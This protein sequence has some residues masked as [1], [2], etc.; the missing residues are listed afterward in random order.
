MKSI[1]PITTTSEL[2][3]LAAVFALAFESEYQLSE[4]YASDMLSNPQQLVLGAWHEMTLI[5][6][7]VACEI[8]P[9]HGSK[10]YYIYDIAVH[11]AHQQKGVGTLLMQQLLVEA[12]VRGIRTVFV[13]AEADDDGAVAFYRTLKG[14]EIGV[15]HFN[16]SVAKLNTAYTKKPMTA[17]LYAHMGN[18]EESESSTRGLLRKRKPGDG[19]GEFTWIQD[20]C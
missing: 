12:K 6:G 11:P 18:I 19:P 1:R 8:Q 20:T 17:L 10:E 16:F 7:L 3:D 14:E 15:R 5:G 4:R 13:E 2:F 9:L